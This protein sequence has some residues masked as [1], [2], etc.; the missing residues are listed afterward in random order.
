MAKVTVI[1]DILI[2][3]EKAAEVLLQISQGQKKRANQI[4]PLMADKTLIIWNWKII[5]CS[6]YSR[7]L[8]IEKQINFSES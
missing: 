4:V 7:L 3:M 8:F 6:I 2:S 1:F 5:N